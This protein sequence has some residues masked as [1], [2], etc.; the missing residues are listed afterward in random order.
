MNAQ[1]LRIATSIAALAIAAATPSFGAT[2]VR[3]SSLPQRYAP[4][5]HQSLVSPEAKKQKQLLYVGDNANNR[6]L[7]Y[8]LK[9]KGQNPA[10]IATITNGVFGPQGITTDESGNLYVTNLFGNNVTIYAPGSLI[11]QRTISQG[12]NSPTDV[13]VDGFG[14]V[15]VA[16]SPGLGAESYVSL[17]PAGSS[18]PS[19]VWYTPV[20]NMIISGITLLNPTMQGETSVY[21]AAYTV[22]PSSELA[23]G[24][25]L[26]C[27][28]GF[29]TCVALFSPFGQTGGIT[30]QQSPG[31]GPSKPFKFA[32]VDQ[33]VPGIDFFSNAQLSSQMVTGGTPEFLTF[34][35]TQTELFLA[36]RQAAGVTEYSWP[37]GQVLNHFYPGKQAAVYGVAVTPAGTYF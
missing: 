20:A 5:V 18:T 24:D 11:P 21:A 7:V 22:N 2:I 34:N 32:L 10:P 37:G 12:I 16:N 26:S 13:K 4:Q 35:S 29:G 36:D 8:K 14:N 27:Y 28:P 1:F 3:G 33:Y 19:S 25:V 9:G 6:I 30:V 17:Y 31:G 23:T 15:Y